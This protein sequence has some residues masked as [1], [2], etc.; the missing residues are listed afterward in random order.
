[1]N[2]KITE[3][4]DLLLQSGIVKKH[5]DERFEA[6]KTLRKREESGSPPEV[7]TLDQLG[8]AFIFIAI[9]LTLSCVVF[10]IELF[11]GKVQKI[12]LRKFS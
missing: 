11:V 5:E 8:L 12:I 3:N 6:I 4:I 10:V 9:M 2:K 7:L 1:M